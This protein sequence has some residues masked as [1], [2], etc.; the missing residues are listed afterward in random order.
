V[1]RRDVNR[2][3]VSQHDGCPRSAWAHFARVCR[4]EWES[5]ENV[6]ESVTLTY[7]LLE[8]VQ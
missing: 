1:A 5:D 8:L 4:E 6:I 7:D 3:D 2:R